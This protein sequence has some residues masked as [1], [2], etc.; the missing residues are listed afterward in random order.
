M[1]TQG[2]SDRV[3]RISKLGPDREPP[4]ALTVEGGRVAGVNQQRQHFSVCVD[5]IFGEGRGP[6]HVLQRYFILLKRF[7]GANVF[8]QEFLRAHKGSLQGKLL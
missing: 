2:G 4:Q 6:G 7:L 5:V 1:K 3:R 8:V